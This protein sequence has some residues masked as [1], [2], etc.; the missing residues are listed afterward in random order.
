MPGSIKK[1]CNDFIDQNA[2][3]IIQ[4]LIA[5]LDPSDICTMMKFC[6]DGFENIRG[7]N[8]LKTYH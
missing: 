7:K 6:G 1:Q 3:A 5:T 2:Q 4:L 8:I